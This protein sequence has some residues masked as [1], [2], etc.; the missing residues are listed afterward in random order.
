MT[1]NHTPTRI[2]GFSRNASDLFKIATT[3]AGFPAGALM[4]EIHRHAPN[5]ATVATVEQA[6]QIV[7]ARA[8]LAKGA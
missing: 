3:L 6:M 1:T 2:E 7:A 5:F 8:A 4:L